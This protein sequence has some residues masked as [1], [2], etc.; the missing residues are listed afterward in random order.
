MTQA[1]PERSPR[2]GL[3][4]FRVLAKHLPSP[5]AGAKWLDLGGGAGEFSR[6]AVQQGYEVT[7][8]DDDSRNIANVTGPGIH[9]FL[10]DLNHPLAQFNDVTFDGVSLI[11]VV[12]HVPGAERLMRE[13]H[14]LLKSGGVL[15]LSTPNAAWWQERVRIL[16]GRPL[17]AEGY[18][19]RFF[20]VSGVHALC[21]EAGF[22]VAHIEFSTPAF[23]VNLLRRLFLRRTKRVHVRVPSPLAGLLAQTVYVVGKKP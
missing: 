22:D 14:R 12:E 10:A 6:L 17:A 21:R 4:R 1:L 11:E 16:F 13:A 15:L 8:V 3:H 2:P 20:T 9:A 18:H 7:L 19:Y 23:G 5:S